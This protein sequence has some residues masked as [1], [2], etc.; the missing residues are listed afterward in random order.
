MWQLLFFI[1]WWFRGYTGCRLWDW[2]LFTGADNP[3]ISAVLHWGG[4]WG[5]WRWC[6]YTWVLPGDR[7]GSTVAQLWWLDCLVSRTDE[8]I[9]KQMLWMAFLSLEVSRISGFIIFSF[10]FFFVRKIIEL[11]QLGYQ[12]VYFTFNLMSWNNR[13]LWVFIGCIEHKEIRKCYSL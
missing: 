3:E 8:F 7:C 5:R 10:T 4:Y 11:M 12:W 2:S 6:E 1:G 9:I 13:A